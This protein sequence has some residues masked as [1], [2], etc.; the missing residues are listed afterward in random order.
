MIF[1]SK[2]WQDIRRYF[3]H[4]YVKFKE[5]GDRIWFIKSVT[6]EEVRA[7][8]VDGFEVCIDLS[9]EYEIDYALPTRAV[10]QNG[11]DAHL[12]IRFPYKQYFRGIHELN[13]K[14][15]KL[16]QNGAWKAVPL[17]FENIQQYVE[18]PSYQKD[19]YKI[20]KYNSWALNPDISLSSQGHIFCGVV[21]IGYLPM[22]GSALKKGKACLLF[23]EELKDLFPDV[24]FDYV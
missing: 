23:K 5:T 1:H 21:Q 9:E 4:T 6:S 14:V 7:V 10:Y 22:S 16:N 19:S 20:N 11:P 12:L 24:T 8:D 2:N 15:F 18:K 13:T 17:C 3:A